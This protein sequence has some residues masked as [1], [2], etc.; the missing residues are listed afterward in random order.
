MSGLGV[1]GVTTGVTVLVKG[2][3]VNRAVSWRIH[4]QIHCRQ[5][6]VIRHWRKSVHGFYSSGKDAVLFK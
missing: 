5:V 1:T 2:D 6:M 3:Q 4:S